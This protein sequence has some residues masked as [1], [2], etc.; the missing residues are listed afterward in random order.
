MVSQVKKNAVRAA[1]PD[2]K[3]A[4]PDCLFLKT[5]GVIPLP[6]WDCTAF[7]YCNQ[8]T[9]VSPFLSKGKDP[10]KGPHF[11]QQNETTDKESSLAKQ[12]L[13]SLIREW[14]GKSSCYKD[15]SS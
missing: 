7:L 14:S 8:R 6:G 12:K 5:S 11:H 15:T 10:N 1:Q 2:K 4:G 9:K 3:P 13:Y